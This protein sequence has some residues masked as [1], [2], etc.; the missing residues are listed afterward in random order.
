MGSGIGG[1]DAAAAAVA[2]SHHVGRKGAIAWH[3]FGPSL[4]GCVNSGNVRDFGLQSGNKTLQQ[5][6]ALLRVCLFQR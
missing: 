4:V 6:S 1:T 3:T 5:I 2:F